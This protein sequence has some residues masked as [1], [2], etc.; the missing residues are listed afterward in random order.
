MAKEVLLQSMYWGPV[1]YY[2]K[3]YNASALIIEQHDHYAKQT[4]RNRCDIVSANGKMSL[5]VPVEKR[6]NPKTP[7]KDI[8]LF[9]EYSWQRV[10]IKSLETAYN[11]TPFFEYYFDDV[12]PVLTKKWDFLIDL[13]A[14]TLEALFF[15][16]DKRIPFSLSKSYEVEPESLDLRNTILPKNDAYKNDADFS[17]KPYYQ[18]FSDKYGFLENLSILDLLFNMGPET[19]DVLRASNLSLA[20]G[21]K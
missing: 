12:L 16:L 13:N 1:H 7:V 2:T 6:K 20:E 21:E 17:P 9:S 8:R 3:V 14:A 10:H 5:T 15:M 4:Y 11:S 19:I 18:V